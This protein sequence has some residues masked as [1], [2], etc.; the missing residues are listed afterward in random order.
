MKSNVSKAKEASE[1]MQRHEVAPNGMPTAGDLREGMH[2]ASVSATPSGATPDPD[3]GVAAMGTPTADSAMAPLD[4]ERK[5]PTET[6]DERDARRIEELARKMKM[7]RTRR[8]KRQIAN[9]KVVL[10]KTMSEIVSYH[11]K[12][13][14]DAKFT[15]DVLVRLGAKAEELGLSPADL[16]AKLREVVPPKQA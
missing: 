14:R 1:A 7:V 9:E 10:K 8:H 16:F 13:P 5:K 15:I 3:V 11:A 12:L 6:L 2:Q 4:I